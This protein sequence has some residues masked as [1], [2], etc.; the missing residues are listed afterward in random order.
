MTQDEQRW[1]AEEDA[2]YLA[3]VEEIKA[4]PTRMAKARSAAARIVKDEEKRLKGIQKVA[5]KK[6]K[7][8]PAPQ[9]GASAFLPESPTKASGLKFGLGSQPGT[10]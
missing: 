1:R 4:D 5:G 8:E 6:V 3:T 2:R 7:L 10:Y 9:S